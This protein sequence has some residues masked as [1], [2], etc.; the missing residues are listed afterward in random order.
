MPSAC[1]TGTTACDMKSFSQTASGTSCHRRPV[2]KASRVSL[3]ALR[4]AFAAVLF[5]TVAIGACGA[6]SPVAPTT[7]VTL[8][9]RNERAV[10]VWFGAR[11]VT[12]PPIAIGFGPDVGVGCFDVAIGSEIVMFDR[13]PARG[14]NLVKVIARISPAA[15]GTRQQI[16]VDVTA[17][18]SVSTGQGI[19]HW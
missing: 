14:G 9:G 19:P 12:N 8:Y 11:P 4:L 2:F 6:T 1:G 5:G 16:W 7:P 15:G 17:D 13:S 3:V 10:E 18:G